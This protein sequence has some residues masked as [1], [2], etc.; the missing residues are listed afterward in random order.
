MTHNDPHEEALCFTSGGKKLIGITHFPDA[1]THPENATIGVIIVVGGPQY[2]I[3]AHRQYVHMARFLASHGIPV[4]RFDYQGIGDSEGQYPGFEHV[5]ADIYAAIDK[6]QQQLPTLHNIAL[7]GLCEGASALLLGGAEHPAVSHIV[8]A[9]S[10]VRTEESHAKAMVKHYYFAKFKDPAFW[11]KLLSLKID[12]PKALASAS[13]SLLG[14]FKS[15]N[16]D[17]SGSPFPQRMLQ[18]LKDFKGHVLL[19]HSGNDLTA[20]EFED[21][22][23]SD[24]DWK[25]VLS[26]TKLKRAFI[27]DSDHTFSSEQWRTEA[28]SATLDF[29]QI[30]ALSKK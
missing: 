9:N 17:N 22:I 11:R 27:N 14:M 8:L 2:R 10:W 18:G 5:S 12:I 24:S 19:L 21:L 1:S 29:L 7:W 30:S 16:P 25:D 4:F 6:F 26:H 15:P 28:A 23:T 3:G 20:R 13:N